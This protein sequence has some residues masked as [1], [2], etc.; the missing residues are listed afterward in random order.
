MGQASC[1]V[2]ALVPWAPR[3]VRPWAQDL[4][5]NARHLPVSELLEADPGALLGR[6]VAPTLRWD[7]A[8]QCRGSAQPCSHR[9]QKSS[10]F[11]RVQP[12]A[13]CA[14]LLLPVT[15]ITALAAH[16][17]FQTWIKIPLKQ[18]DGRGYLCFWFSMAPLLH[19]HPKRAR[20]IPAW[21]L[22]GIAPRKVEM[23]L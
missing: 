8:P 22:Q 13:A 16:D 21:A 6:G 17:P 1:I 12:R 4:L 10:S 23:P 14:H 7:L 2:A 5:P 18:P 3:E 15:A 20:S 11:P 9:A 19:L